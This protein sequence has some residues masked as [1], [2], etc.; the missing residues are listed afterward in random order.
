MISSCSCRHRILFSPFVQIVFCFLSTSFFSPF[1][2]SQ[3]LLNPNNCSTMTVQY[4]SRTPGFKTRFQ[5]LLIG[6][7]PEDKR[8]GPE[9][10]VLTPKWLNSRTKEVLSIADA[11]VISMLIILRIEIS[12]FR[13]KGI[14]LK[15]VIWLH[16][17]N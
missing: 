15:L 17:L 3:A 13:V 11:R 5:R 14:P 4:Q 6:R 12:Y 16:F 9:N 8:S 1:W 10:M 2:A 7:K